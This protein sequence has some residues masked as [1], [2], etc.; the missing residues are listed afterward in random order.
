MRWVCGAFAAPFEAIS[1]ASDCRPGPNRSST[2][3]RTAWH[4]DAVDTDVSAYLDNEPSQS[5]L[6]EIATRLGSLFSGRLTAIDEETIREQL[7]AAGMY[8]ISPRTIIGYRVL[9]TIG[10]PVLAFLLR[11]GRDTA[12]RF[13][14]CRAEHLCRMGVATH[15]R[16]AQGA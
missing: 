11:L 16:P 9:L 8:T 14:D 4:E 12:A 3:E 6:S 2:S 7:M 10:L 15:V 1:R 13:A 5:P